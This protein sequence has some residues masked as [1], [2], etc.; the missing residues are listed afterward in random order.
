[1][2][3]KWF[4]VRGH[5]RKYYQDAFEHVF[6]HALGYRVCFFSI[7]D[8]LVFY[9]IFAIYSRSYGIV[10]LALALMFN[11]F[12]V[13]IHA[14]TSRVMSQFIG[15]VTSTYVKA[16]NRDSGR[17]GPLFEKAFGNS[18]K[19]A[20]KKIRT[21]IS[22]CYNNSVEKKLFARAEDDR[23]NFLAYIGNRHPFSP[24]LALEKASKYLRSALKEVDAHVRDQAYLRYACIRRLFKNLQ[25]MEREQLIDYI[26]SC[27]LPI[28]KESLLNFY[29]DYDSMLLAI[30]SNTGSEYDI[31][32][33]YR[34]DSD[35]AYSEML[36]VVAR[37]SYAR[38]PHSILS[39]SPAEKKRIAYSLKRLVGA[40]DYQISRLLHDEDWL[41]IGY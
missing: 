5:R 7:E 3:S 27:Y 29:K 36:N 24:P 33:E 2:I 1:M 37:S 14:P 21:C 25:T 41:P 38:N 10:V 23:W 6:Q 8:R 17:K 30:N 28:D 18:P 19:S 20:E 31:K 16:F 15:T 26:I 11:H 35:L 39:A 9:T 40:K 32:E 13:L 12:H 22:Y 34:N 4:V